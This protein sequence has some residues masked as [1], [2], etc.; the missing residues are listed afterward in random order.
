MTTTEI[1]NQVLAL[2]PAERAAIAQRVWESIEDD[3]EVVS[4]ESD[5]EAISI[6]QRRDE[7]IASGDVAQRT[8]EEVMRNARRAIQCE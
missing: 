2:P 3:N 4:P 6:A 1:T 8:H 5:A 7:E